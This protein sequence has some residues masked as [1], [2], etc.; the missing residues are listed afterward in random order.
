LVRSSDEVTLE[1]DGAWSPWPGRVHAKTA[2]V[3]FHDYNVEMQLVVT[4]ARVNV[5]L[6]DLAARRFHATRV[7]ARDVRFAL[8]HKVVDVDGDEKRLPRFPKI[9]GFADPPLYRGSPSPPT[10]DSEYRSWT[11]HLDDVDVAVSEIWIVEYRYHGTARA[12]GSFRL[13]PGRRLL[14]GPATLDIQAGSIHAGDA[15]VLEDVEGS[16]ECTVRD[17]DV[18]E[19]EGLEVL[20]NVSAT[21]RLDARRAHADVSRLYAAGEEAPFAGTG[22]LHAEVRVDDGAL[23]RPTV[24]SV[25]STDAVV[26]K[27][28]FSVEGPTDLHFDLT[29]TPEPRPRLRA[30]SKRLAVRV[31]ET[32]NDVTPL[33][34]TDPLMA[35][36][37]DGADLSKPMAPSAAT[38][39][40]PRF[41]LTDV[42]WINSRHDCEP[43][44]P[45][46]H[47]T[48]CSLCL[49]NW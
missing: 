28:R 23:V 4:G 27:G 29:E 5:D 37:L 21:I 33:E 45:P 39:E 47:S 35:V 13:R 1:L 44:S 36:E 18:R 20:E 26:R 42:R 9:P 25:L 2:I 8:R 30:S 38:L 41:S 49:A 19:P 10:P 3:R 6:L 12:R 17:F 22:R 43:I 31:T 32:P 16:I 46:V 48:V 7:R 15:P 34:L 40:I 11:I 24:L 14:V